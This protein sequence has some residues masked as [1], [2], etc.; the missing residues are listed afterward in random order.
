MEDKGM[1]MDK[2]TTGEVISAAKQW[3]LK[4]NTKPIR[5]HPLDGAIFPY[6]IQVTYCIDGQEFRKR[7]WIGAGREVPAVGSTVKVMY[8]SENPR[9]AKII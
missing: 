4:I 3:W 7:K 8:C 6:I 1:M 5:L 2:E 9:K